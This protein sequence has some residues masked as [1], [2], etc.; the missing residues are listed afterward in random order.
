MME[1]KTKQKLTKETKGFSILVSFIVFSAFRLAS[2]QRRLAVSF[3]RVF[4]VFSASNFEFRI[5][6]F[7]AHD[8]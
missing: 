4:R 7:P 1:D 5:S 3:F 8:R 2:H 6:G